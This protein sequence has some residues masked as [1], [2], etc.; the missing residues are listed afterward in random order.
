[1]LSHCIKL[2]FCW[3]S[4]FTP[5]QRHGV[6]LLSATSDVQRATLCLHE[7]ATYSIQCHYLTGSTALGCSY[8][9]TSVREGVEHINGTI[10]RNATAEMKLKFSRR[11]FDDIVYVY[12]WEEDGSFG[13]LPFVLAVSDAKHCS[14]TVNPCAS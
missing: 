1:M 12:D 8:I 11:S 7:A 14:G 3:I 2:R 6:F 4:E 13:R 9:I 10:D 5:Y